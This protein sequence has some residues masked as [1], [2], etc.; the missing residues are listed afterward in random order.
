M[1]VCYLKKCLPSKQRIRHIVLLEYIYLHGF[2]QLCIISTTLPLTQVHFGSESSP[3]PE[4]YQ[5]E[6][7]TEA[8]GTFGTYSDFSGRGECHVP[9]CGILCRKAIHF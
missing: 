6:I 1:Y 7:Q 4:T 5:A 2:F 9:S 3:A 8:G